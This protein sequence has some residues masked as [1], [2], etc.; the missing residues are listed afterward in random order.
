MQTGTV[1]SIA[2]RCLLIFCFK[3]SLWEKNNI[4]QKCICM[5]GSR[6]TS[7]SYVRLRNDFECGS[8]TYT[9]LIHRKNV[10]CTFVSWGSIKHF[11]NL[12]RVNIWNVI[13]PN[14]SRL[15]V[16]KTRFSLKPKP[17]NLHNF[18]NVDRVQIVSEVNSKNYSF[19]Q[20]RSVLGLSLDRLVE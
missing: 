16:L 12:P 5:K 7:K 8:S 10:R 15:F 6:H 9:R 18:E 3:I 20:D 14:W 2:I 1:V 13:I 19:Y 11:L 4:S 17:L